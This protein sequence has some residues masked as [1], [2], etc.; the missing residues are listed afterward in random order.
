MLEEHVGIVPLLA[1]N[2]PGPSGEL[3][4]FVLLASQSQVTPT[5]RGHQRRVALPAGVG[6]AESRVVIPKRFVYLAVEPRWMPEFK[7]RPPTPG[8]EIKKRAKAFQV[9]LEIGWKL[10]QRRAKLGP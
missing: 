2:V 6:D 8:Q 9:L 1:S 3:A 10:K 7:C 4:G 5:R